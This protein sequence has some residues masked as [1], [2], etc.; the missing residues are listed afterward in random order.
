[1]LYKFRSKAAGDVIMT[2]PV[3]DAVLRAMGR[4]PTVKGIFEA[5]ALPSLVQALESAVAADD[6]Q[7]HCASG[8]SDEATGAATDRVSLKQRAWPLLEMM[9]R[10]ASA[11]HDIVWG[12]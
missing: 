1:M 12:V 3:G 9:K 4:E 6:A 2:A 11:G 7:R 5:G 10:A 8:D